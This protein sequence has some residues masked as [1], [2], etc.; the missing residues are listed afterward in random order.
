MSAQASATRPWWKG[1][2]IY[3]IYPLS[4]ADSNGDGYGDLPGITS[5]LE[6][7]A[8]LGVE[9][10]WISPFYPSPM[11]DFGYD[12]SDYCNVDP[13]FG[14]LADFDRLSER[15]HTLGLRVIIDQVLSHTSDQHAWFRES[16]ASRDN[17]KADWYVWANPKPDGTPPCNWQSV[18][19]GPAWEWDARRGQ[20]YL[21]NFLREQPDLNVHNPQVQ[22]ALLQAARFWLDRGVDGFRFDAINFAMHDPLLRDN[23]PAP[24]NGKPRSR[25]FDFQISVYNKSHTDIPRFIRRLRSLL[26]SYPDRFSVAEV[27]G[28]DAESE[29]HRFTSGSEHFHSAYG[30]NFLNADRLTPQ[31]IERAIT[32]WPD[33]LHIGW[34]S[35]AFSNHD[36]PRV[37][38]RWACTEDREAMAQVAMLLLA[39][40][41]GNIFV[42]QGEELGL[43]QAHIPFDQLKDPEAIA[44]WPLTL[45]R[46]G[47]RTPM[48]WTSN[49]SDYQRSWLPVPLQHL[50]LAVEH[51]YDAHTSM[52]AFTR[53]ALA[54]RRQNEALL[55]G[56]MK[57]LVANESILAFERTSERERLL[58]VF[59][60]GR[61]RQEWRP[62]DPK[63]WRIFASTGA[64][65]QLRWNFDGYSGAVASYT[66]EY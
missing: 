42:Y 15:A 56:A 8:A 29:M 20:Y 36:A 61:N 5:R 22:D 46:D 33:E 65:D 10:V 52:L 44:N 43:P 9:G 62:A 4:F 1:A 41:R 7:I 38:S 55:C 51:Q 35:W 17:P 66:P 6:H 11:K 49:A 59:N 37:T 14:T 25:P 30:F 12:V 2:A 24:D 28:P 23:P 64:I 26:D 53:R 34:P 31:L 54:L 39:C 58:C 13:I 32:A 19:G 45:G 60:L 3:Q 27:G 21:H 47:A 18:F 57:I 16:R 48:P 50:Q 40:L 63:S